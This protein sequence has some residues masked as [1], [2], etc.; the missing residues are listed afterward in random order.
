[1]PSPPSVF[2]HPWG[3]EIQSKPDSFDRRTWIDLNCEEKDAEI[4]WPGNFEENDDQKTYPPPFFKTNS[5]L[6]WTNVWLLSFIW[7]KIVNN[8]RKDGRFFVL[9]INIMLTDFWIVTT[10][11]LSQDL[12]TCEVNKS[13]SHYR[14]ERK[15]S[16]R[17]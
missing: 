5:N 14:S 7:L 11:A 1:M 10:V 9:P 6:S 3:W 13:E 2:V 12:R 16:F 4:W 15:Q 8:F 17:K